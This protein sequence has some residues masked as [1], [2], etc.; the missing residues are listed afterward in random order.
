ME[1][2]KGQ[3]RRVR[4]RLKIFVTDPNALDLIDKLMTLNPARRIN[5]DE[6]LDHGFFWE[7]PMPNEE[8]F[9]KMLSHHTTNMFEML[10]PPRQRHPHHGRQHAASAANAQGGAPTQQKVGQHFDRV[11]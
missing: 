8:S 1:L 7:E 5:A 11:F 3:H 2:P 10:A 9:A 6:T 4:E